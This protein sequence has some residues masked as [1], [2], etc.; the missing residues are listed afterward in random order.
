[1][2][3]ARFKIEKVVAYIAGYLEYELYY[4]KTR[5]LRGSQA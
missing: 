2:N 4:W 5:Y 3:S 1:M